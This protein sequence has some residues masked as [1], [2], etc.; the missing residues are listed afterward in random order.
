MKN[1]TES[2][3]RLYL[4]AIV[5]AI[6]IINAGIGFMYIEEVKSQG[7]YFELKAAN[8]NQYA[9]VKKIRN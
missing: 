3:V 1:S 9:D 4:I 5:I 7:Y 2:S 8:D 6:L